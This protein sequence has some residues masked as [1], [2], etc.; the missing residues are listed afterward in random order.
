M[1][2]NSVG[3]QS[4]AIN[5]PKNIRTN[6]FF[7]MNYPEIYAKIEE[8]TLSKIFTTDGKQA[9]THFDKAMMPYLSDPFR[10]V[11]ER[12]FVKEESSIDLEVEAGKEALKLANLNDV[13]LL[14]S[15]GFIP[16]NIGIGNA[17]HVAG[18]LGLG[19]MA[20]NLE[21]ACGGPLAAL[22]TATALV[23]AGEFRNVLVTISCTY[24][25]YAPLDDTMSWFLG[26]GSGAFV[27][28]KVPD[29]EGVIS[30]KN[31]HSADTRGTWFYDL[32]IKNGNP[33]VYM[34]ATKQTGPIM[35]SAAE[36]QLVKC[37]N[38][39]LEKVGL[40][41][42]DIDFFVFHTP[43]AWFHK[44]AANALGIDE[45]KIDS[46]YRFY[47]NIGP[48]LTPTNLH[49]AVSKGKIKQNDLVLVYGPGSS[50]SASAVIMKW[51]QVSTNESPVDLNS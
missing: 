27:V 33:Y 46:P 36:P 23:R 40:S 43:V 6:K 16:E 20:W 39:A 7:R 15:V 49:Y 18:G 47:G 34:G 30:V 21:S 2:T 25:K 14:I 1:N 11:V 19:G 24:T 4:L 26:D 37:C 38:G 32:S 3:L 12:R 45:S 51:G 28:G 10:G 41:L 22:Q 5:V 8:K 48:A 13:D 44:F 31:Y 9:E 35:R 50:S 42:S 17:V 29:G